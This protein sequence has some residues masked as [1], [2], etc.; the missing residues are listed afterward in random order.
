[1]K[2]LRIS[3]Y[4]GRGAWRQQ[5]C[6]YTCTLTG[7]PSVRQQAQDKLLLVPLAVAVIPSRRQL[8]LLSLHIR[9][10]DVI[11]AGRPLR[12]AWRQPALY[13]RLFRAKPVQCLIEVLLVKA[14]QPKVPRLP[15]GSSPSA[16]PTAESP[17]AGLGRAP[18][19]WPTSPDAAAQHLLEPHFSRQC[20]QP[21]NSRKVRTC[22]SIRVSSRR[23]SWWEV[24]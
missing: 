9:G 6:G 21:C 3:A 23:S 16:P 17:G 22:P 8:I 20:Q 12:L 10:G 24:S 11:Q 18:G 15:L 1:M 14:R 13:P 2:P 19:T 4:S 5:G 7:S